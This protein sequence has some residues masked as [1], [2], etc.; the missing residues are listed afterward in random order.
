MRGPRPQAALTWSDIEKALRGKYKQVTGFVPWVNPAT[1]QVEYWTRLLGAA[2]AG[3]GESFSAVILTDFPAEATPGNLREV[4]RSP[5]LAPGDKLSRIALSGDLVTLTRGSCSS[6]GRIG[7]MIFTPTISASELVTPF[8]VA[9]VDGS[10]Q[11]R[12][13][14][15]KGQEGSCRWMGVM[16]KGA[17]GGEKL[18][19]AVG[20]ALKARLLPQRVDLGLWTATEFLSDEDPPGGQHP[21]KCAQA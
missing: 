20:S 3:I 6:L 15:V 2:R 10:P 8:L 21:G 12:V 19:G 7:A 9:P 4:F 16:E 13:L 14:Q 11:P 17:P 18:W 5:I 1:E